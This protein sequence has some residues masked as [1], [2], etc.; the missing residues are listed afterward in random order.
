MRE[1]KREKDRERSL[2]LLP[3]H[4]TPF[5]HM[6]LA[7]NYSDSHMAVNAI[8]DIGYEIALNKMPR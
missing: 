1:R 7:H 3:G 5:L 6:G 8:R 2:M 4:H